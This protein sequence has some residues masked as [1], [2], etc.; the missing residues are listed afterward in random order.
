MKDFLISNLCK[1]NDLAA[2][3]EEIITTL[4]IQQRWSLTN[5]RSKIEVRRFVFDIYIVTE[6]TW[7]H[8]SCLCV[9]M[10]Y[11][12]RTRGGGGRIERKKETESMSRSVTHSLPCGVYCVLQLPSAWT[13]S[14]VLIS[15]VIVPRCPGAQIDFTAATHVRSDTLSLSSSAPAVCDHT[16]FSGIFFQRYVPRPH[17]Y[18]GFSAVRT[19]ATPYTVVSSSSSLCIA[20]TPILR[21]S[22]SA[23]RTVAN[24]NSGILFKRNIPRSHH[25]NGI[26]FQRYVL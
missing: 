18:S 5:F 23:V 3:E 24:S 19:A 6:L 22:L 11:S 2:P 21:Y 15:P 4:S 25:Y 9:S 7:R 10:Q 1:Y 16:S 8:T 13:A 17:R 26:L 12:Q 20:A 14:V